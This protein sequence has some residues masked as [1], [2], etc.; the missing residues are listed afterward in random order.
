MGKLVAVESVTLDGVM[1]APGRPDEDERGGFTHGGW[2]MPYNDPVMGR[3]MGGR[4]ALRDALLF[5]R[6][7]YEDFFGYWPEQRDNPFTPV[8]DA[9]RKYV[10]SRTWRGPLPW[11]NST[12]LDGNA[13]DAVAR[14]KDGGENLTLLGSGELLRS[15]L[16]RADLVDELLLLIHPLVLGSGRRLFEAGTTPRA[17]GLVDAVPTTT[18]VLIA[19]YRPAGPACDSGSA[20]GGSVEGKRRNR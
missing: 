4:M 14:I 2:A 15:L 11:H 10:A 8:L 3:L 16:R 5:G 17:L 9:S 12:L 1:Q 13:T 20:A 7:T 6:R 19:T 18:G